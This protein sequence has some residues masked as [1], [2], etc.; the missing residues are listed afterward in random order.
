MRVVYGNAMP[1]HGTCGPLIDRKPLILLYK[2][3]FKHGPTWFIYRPLSF[4]RLIILNKIKIFRPIFRQITIG[5]QNRPIQRPAF[6]LAKIRIGWVDRP[7]VQ[8]RGRALLSGH[9]GRLRSVG[10]PCW[11]SVGI[12]RLRALLAIDCGPGLASPDMLSERRHKRPCNVLRR[13]LWA[14]RGID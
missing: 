7:C 11:R 5:A 8:Y 13:R 12:D 4:K 9:A 3:I 10:A 14:L 2:I 6:W 1:P